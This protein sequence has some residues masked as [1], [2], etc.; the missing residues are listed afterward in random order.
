MDYSIDF[1]TNGTYYVWLRMNAADLYGHAVHIGVDET[2]I[3]S[4]PAGMYTNTY[5]SWEWTN[6]ALDQS[7]SSPVQ[8]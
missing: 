6:M 2:A 3:T 1:P 7:Q 8:F 5:G 4:T